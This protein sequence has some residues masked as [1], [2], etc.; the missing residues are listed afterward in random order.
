MKKIIALILTIIVSLS[1]LIGCTVDPTISDETVAEALQESPVEDFEYKLNH[2]GNAIM[3]TKYIGNDE[4]IVIP[5]QIEGLPVITL[6]AYESI[7]DGYTVNIGAFQNSNIKSVVIPSSVQYIYKAFANCSQLTQVTFETDSQLETVHYAFE[8]CTALKELDFSSTQLTYIDNFSFAGCKKLKEIKL[9]DSV[10]SIGQKA[11]YECESLEEIVLPNRLE[12]INKFA[13][14][15]CTSLKTITIP[16]KLNIYE[17][18]SMSAFHDIPSLEKV[19]FE[20]GREEIKGYAFISITSDAEII[21]PASVKKLSLWSFFFLNP[22]NAKIIFLGD[23]PEFLNEK[24]DEF[25]AVPTIYYDPNTEGWD[26]CILKEVG[27]TLLP[28][29]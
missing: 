22:A 16:A 1:A 17:V 7:E 28:T 13:F 5:S 12:E 3:V 20:E 8:N 19:I 18:Q 23:C 10:K 9:P 24:L 14:G 26:N 29:E 21:I 25:Y 4:H 6:Y 27:Y 15:Y 11:F 2:L